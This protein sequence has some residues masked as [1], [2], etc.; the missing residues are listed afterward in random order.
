MLVVI[1]LKRIIL[2]FGVLLTVVCVLFS[3]GSDAVVSTISEYDIFVYSDL[4]SSDTEEV[5][6][7][8]D[9]ANE[10]SNNEEFEY[11]L[12][13]S[14]RKFHYPD[15]R[16]VKLMKEENTLYQLGERDAIIYRGFSPCQHCMP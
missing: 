4:E 6:S 14:T 12:N 10:D 2:L 9:E 3:C 16:S 8:S 5:E 1:V 15:C 7:S 13:K 11:V